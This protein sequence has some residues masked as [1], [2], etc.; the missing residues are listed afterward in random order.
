MVHN[1]P[2]DGLRNCIEL[3]ALCF[4][5]CVEECGKGMAEI[6]TTAATVADIEYPFELGQQGVL[7]I[8]RL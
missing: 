4:I 8:E 2:V 3:H 5:D 6:E 7:V 1:V